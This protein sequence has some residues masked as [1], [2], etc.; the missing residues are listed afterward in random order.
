MGGM[1]RDISERRQREAR[2]HRLAHHDALTGLP[3]RVQFDERL[4]STLADEGQVSVVLLDLDGF[5][6]VNDSLGHLAGDALLQSMAVR[7]LAALPADN[8]VCRFGG[9]EFAVLLPGVADPIKA[10]DCAEAILHAFEQPFTIQGH[11]LKPGVSIGIAVGPAHAADA[12][13]L[14]ACADLALYQSKQCGG[15][16]F[17]FF[18]PSMRSAGAIRRELQ[19]ELLE[20][21]NQGQFELFYQPQVEME[22][23]AICGFEALLR[24]RHPARGLLAPAAF[25][26]VLESHTLALEAGC[27][28][29]DQAC[30]Q[31]AEWRQFQP[32]LRVSVN[33]FAAQVN[34]G[35]L[36]EAVADCLQR[37]HLPARALE[38]EVTETIVLGN[39]KPTLA[40]FYKLQRSGVRIAFDDFGTGH[41]SLSML[42]RFPL[43]TL[44]IDR[45]FI[46]EIESAGQDA[47]IVRALLMMSNDLQLDVVAEGIETRSQET[48]LKAMGCSIGQGYLYARPLPASSFLGWPNA[49]VGVVRPGA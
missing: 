30:R 45:S 27:W 15:R 49:L 43:T 21:M 41:A 46:C 28:V 23:G 19:D 35:N 20:A 11:L 31:L 25:L 5:K 12:E 48:L 29:L 36:A 47:A 39:D 44:K 42:R 16:S 17:R 24:W 2:L 38:L 1:I 10:G 34:A 9:D 37:Y 6:K 26:P 7:L 13:E 32:D 33:L 22:S 40:P 8:M 4:R 3:N 18:E 14:V